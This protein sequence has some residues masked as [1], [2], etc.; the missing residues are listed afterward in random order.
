MTKEIAQV[1]L[2]KIEDI[3]IDL[4]HVKSELKVFLSGV[5]TAPERQTEKEKLNEALKLKV[6]KRFQ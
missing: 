2:S 1:L 3:E 6:K 5:A 4:S